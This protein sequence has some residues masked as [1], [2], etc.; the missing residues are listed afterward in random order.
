MYTTDTA[1]YTAY[2]DHRAY[3]PAE[4]ERNLMRAVLKSAMDDMTRRGEARRDARLFFTSDDDD[5]L[6]SFVSIC[7]HLA[8]CPHTIREL[9]GIRP[10]VSIADRMAA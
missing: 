6:L 4:S 3:D 2:D 10:T 9:V 5:Y 1:I 7:R 8:L